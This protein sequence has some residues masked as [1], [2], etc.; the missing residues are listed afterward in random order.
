MRVKVYKIYLYRKICFK[1]EAI[2][3]DILANSSCQGKKKSLDVLLNGQASAS[4]PP[5]NPQTRT[6]RKHAA[7]MNEIPTDKTLQS[8]TS[9]RKALW[10]KV[11]SHHRTS[12][13][14]FGAGPLGSKQHFKTPADQKRVPKR[15]LTVMPGL[16]RLL[17]QRVDSLRSPSRALHYGAHV[18]LLCPAPSNW[19]SRVLR[20]LK[21]NSPFRWSSRHVSFPILPFFQ[22]NWRVCCTL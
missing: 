20:L 13:R 9:S 5:R 8:H 7:L 22:W 1:E 2:A 21:G 3:T 16:L 12:F 15:N 4:P 17:P 19:P 18:L 11:A 6:Q 14:S 10:S